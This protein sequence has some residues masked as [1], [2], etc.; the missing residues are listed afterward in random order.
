MAPLPCIFPVDNTD[1]PGCSGLRSFPAAQID[2]TPEQPFGR[3]VC[4][5]ADDLARP[6]DVGDIGLQG[7]CQAGYL[8]AVDV[9]HVGVRERR[10]LVHGG[11]L[12]LE[13]VAAMVTLGDRNSRVK[14]FFDLHHVASRFPFDRTTLV[15]AVRRTFA[16]R[17]TPI[18]DKVPIAL[19]RAYWDNPFRPA[20]IRVLPTV[21]RRGGRGFRGRVLADPRRVSLACARGSAREYG[22]FGDLAAGR[23]VAMT[24][25]ARGSSV[26]CVRPQPKLAQGVTVT[27]RNPFFAVDLTPV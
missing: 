4:R 20:Q 15:E 9:G 5:R 3:H 12:E 8:L 1:P 14:D 21:A 17:Q 25:G 27:R 18:P 22:A 26:R 10:R 19:T 7:L 23:A 6:R 16:R 2:R 11:E 24:M 13:F